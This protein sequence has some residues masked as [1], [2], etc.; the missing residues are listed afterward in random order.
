MKNYLVLAA[1]L[2][3]SVFFSCKKADTSDAAPT[4]DFVIKN[5][6]AEVNEGASLM[7]SNN[8]TS[9]KAVTYLWD[10]GNGKTS[11]EKDPVMAYGMHGDYNVKLTVTDATGRTSVTAK[12]ITVLCIFATRNH[13][14]L[15]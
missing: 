5:T 1:I 9:S 14:A 7:V 6:N 10:F 4:S 3:V 13:P 11:T 2:F 12:T 8:S 15:F